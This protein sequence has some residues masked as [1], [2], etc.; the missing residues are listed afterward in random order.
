MYKCGRGGESCVFWWDNFTLHLP[1]PLEHRGHLIIIIIYQ[2]SGLQAWQQPHQN[3]LEDLRHPIIPLLHRY[4]A[5]APPHPRYSFLRP[6]LYI[7]E[8]L[9]FSAVC[10]VHCNLAEL[11]IVADVL[12]SFT[13]VVTATCI[14]VH[15]S[16]ACM[17][18]RMY[19]SN[20]QGAV[21][22]TITVTTTFPF[23]MQTIWNY[24]IY[25]RYLET[26]WALGHVD[27]SASA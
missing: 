13:V 24:P 20:L 5:A 12:V 14:Y 25:R 22:N 2:R 7:N 19:C 18:I 11:F 15:A 26:P 21:H 8:L 23:S 16:Y 4:C 6:E 9:F 1:P 17:Q 3:F 27:A 10:C